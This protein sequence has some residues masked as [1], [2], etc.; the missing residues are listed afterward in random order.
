MR[1]SGSGRPTGSGA[2]L[3]GLVG[4]RQAVFVPLRPA[5]EEP[6]QLVEAFLDRDA[7]HAGGGLRPHPAG[8]TDTLKTPRMEEDH[9]AFGS[10]SHSSSP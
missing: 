9:T 3:L 8:R 6:D 4:I 5:L 2:L 10:G 1:G 7:G